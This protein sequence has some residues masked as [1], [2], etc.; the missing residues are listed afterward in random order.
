MKNLLFLL[1][2]PALLFGQS[3]YQCVLSNAESFFESETAYVIYD[4]PGAKNHIVGLKVTDTID[5]GDYVSYPFYNEFHT[6]DYLISPNSNYCLRADKYS[7]AGPEFQVY[8]NGLNVFFN[9][10]D[11]PVF[12]NTQANL[13]ETWTFY[14]DSSGN[15]YVA[16]ITDISEKKFLGVIDSVKTIEI[17]GDSSFTI[18]ISKNYGFIKTI[19]FRDFPGFGENTFSVYQYDLVGLSEPELG[20]HRLDK[21]DIFSFEEGDEVHW[22]WKDGYGDYTITHSYIETYL[23]KTIISE[24]T[25]VYTLNRIHWYHDAWDSLHY[26]NDTIMDTLVNEEMFSGKL[27]IEDIIEDSLY[28]NR[29]IMFES[30]DYNRIVLDNQKMNDGHYLIDTNCYT[31]FEVFVNFVHIYYIQGVG[32]FWNTIW[33]GSGGT[34]KSYPCYFSK[35]D[36]EWGTP[37]TPPDGIPLVNLRTSISISPNPTSH[38]AKIKLKN[39]AHYKHITLEITDLTGKKI[40]SQ[41]IQK[42]QTETTLNV[43]SWEKG[44]YFVVVRADGEIVG[45]SKLVVN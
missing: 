31:V 9:R 27:P 20:T 10:D 42:S 39:T 28:L 30:N 29:Y 15:D 21:F 19:N 16:T 5:M 7:W 37:L 44:I 11:N 45:R 25:I 12:I 35:S 13:G 34:N 4:H 43:A 6:D 18:E 38:T 41:K 23:D 36:G 1:F 8:E 14:S 2:M 17:A 24:D 22:K 3:D 33:E 40:S 32:I 26:S